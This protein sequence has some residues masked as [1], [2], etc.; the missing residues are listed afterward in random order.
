MFNHCLGI[1]DVSAET[2]HEAE[3]VKQRI[4]DDLH[5]YY[6]QEMRCPEGNYARRLCDL[7]SLITATEKIMARKKED[8]VM[9]RTFNLYKMDEVMTELIG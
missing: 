5:V 4:A 3:T 6:V 7:M 1:P 8:M 2:R 9:A